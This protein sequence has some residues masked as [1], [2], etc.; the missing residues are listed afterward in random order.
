[1]LVHL[2]L[3][4]EKFDLFNKEVLL[5]HKKEQKRTEATTC[6]R[7]FSDYQTKVT[8]KAQH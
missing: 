6:D 2:L 5:K 3:K 1:M 7:K 4:L 8:N